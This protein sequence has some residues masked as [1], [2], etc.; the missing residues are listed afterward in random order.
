MMLTQVRLSL[1]IHCMLLANQ[2]RDSKSHGG[3][4]VLR[5]SSDRDD[6]KDSFGLKFSILGCF[7]VASPSQAKNRLCSRGLKAWIP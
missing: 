6:R 5:I 3:G 2:K 4:A 1:K 7:W